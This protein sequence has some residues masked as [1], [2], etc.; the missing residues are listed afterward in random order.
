[1]SVSGEFVGSNPYERLA[2]LYE[3]RR[4]YGSALRVSEAYMGLA[5]SGKRPKGAQRS[6]DRKLPDF[7]TRMERYRRQLGGD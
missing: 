5:A 2:S 4:D 7:E 1:M 6:A 3:R